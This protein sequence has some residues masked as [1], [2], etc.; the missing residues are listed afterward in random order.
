MLASLKRFEDMGEKLVVNGKNFFPASSN[1]QAFIN[2]YKLMLEVGGGPK[3]VN[4]LS[5]L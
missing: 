2:E 5:R 1:T 3:S 4:T